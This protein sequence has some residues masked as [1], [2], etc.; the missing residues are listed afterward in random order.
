MLLLA[1]TTP[2]IA[3]PARSHHDLGTMTRCPA[4]LLRD[5]FS[6]C[7][8]ELALTRGLGVEDDNRGEAQGEQPRGSC[9]FHSE[10]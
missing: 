3:I 10:D 5:I 1:Q 9:L 7:V 2:L 4:D 6:E 8:G